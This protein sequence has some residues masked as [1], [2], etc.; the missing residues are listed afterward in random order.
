MVGDKSS[1]EQGAAVLVE[2]FGP[3]QLLSLRTN[4]LLFKVI[5]KSDSLTLRLIQSGLCALWMEAEF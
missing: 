1:G 2:L 3:L 4:E 5:D